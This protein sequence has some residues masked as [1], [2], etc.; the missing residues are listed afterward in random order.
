MAISLF[1]GLQDSWPD[2]IWIEGHFIALW[3]HDRHA[4]LPISRS[5][6]PLHCSAHETYLIDI[7][8]H[9]VLKANKTTYFHPHPRWFFL[10]HQVTWVQYTG[11]VSFEHLVQIFVLIARLDRFV[12]F[13]DKIKVTSTKYY[14][15]LNCKHTQ[16]YWVNLSLSFQFHFQ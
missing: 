6:H 11:L 16:Q 3:L 8:L 9:P 14:S 7:K 15:L 10:M 4:A 5:Y 2:I 1:H 12:P 13:L